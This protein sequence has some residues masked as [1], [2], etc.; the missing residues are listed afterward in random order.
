MNDFIQLKP[1]S[2][3]YEAE[4]MVEGT[5]DGFSFDSDEEADKLP[6]AN[7]TDQN[8]RDE[9][10]TDKK[11]SGK[12]DKTSGNAKKRGRSA[13]G[14]PPAPKKIRKKAQGSKKAKTKR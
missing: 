14:K 5:L 13:G 10:Q 8:E 11:A 3:V 7:Q 12:T 1:Q 6:K 4:T 2:N 9:E